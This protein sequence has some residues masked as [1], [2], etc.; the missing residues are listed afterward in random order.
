MYLVSKWDNYGG[1][2]RGLFLFIFHSDAVRWINNQEDPSEYTIDNIKIHTEEN[3]QN[4]P[5]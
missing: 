2:F 1:L 4:V 5:S 3:E